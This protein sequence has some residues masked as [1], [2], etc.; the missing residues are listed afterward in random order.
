M[1]VSFFCR[2]ILSK[3]T[4]RKARLG[5]QINVYQSANMNQILV[6]LT[7]TAHKIKFESDKRVP[8]S[9]SKYLQF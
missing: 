9:N 5:N 8:V 6:E 7:D 3:D 4:Q 1:G 2:E